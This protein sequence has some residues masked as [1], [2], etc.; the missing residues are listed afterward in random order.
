MEFLTCADFKS[1]ST[2]IVYFQTD[3]FKP[4]VVAVIW[5]KYCQYGVKHFPINISRMFIVIEFKHHFSQKINER[6][7]IAKQIIPNFLS[8]RSIQNLIKIK[9]AINHFKL[10]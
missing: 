6:Y 8:F 2:G 5:L 3:H 7:I 4:I 1:Y 9:Y 10:K